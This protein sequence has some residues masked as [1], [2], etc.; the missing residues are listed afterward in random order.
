M[1]SMKPLR[2]R[3]TLW[4]AL[5]LT[6]VVGCRRSDLYTR[7][8]PSAEDPAPNFLVLVVDDWARS[9]LD[10]ARSDGNPWN[11]LINV[12]A[13]ASQ[14]VSWNHFYTQTVCNPT[15]ATM[16]FGVYEG[17]TTGGVCNKPNADTPASD[18]LT[19]ARL[20][21]DDRGYATAAFGKWHIGTN[22]DPAGNWI[23]TPE[24]YGFDHWR[25]W[26]ASNLNGHCSSKS[27]T[28]WHR[29]DDGVASRSTEYHT[30][31]V[32]NAAREWWQATA[33]PKFA[34]VCFQA[35]HA[36]FH[37]PPA[38]LLPSGYPAPTTKHEEYESMLVAL[39]TMV[40]S[41][42]AVVDPD[43]TYVLLLGDNGTPSGAARADQDRSRVKAS[44]FQDGVNVPFIVTGP[45][46]PFGETSSLGHAVDLMATLAELA[47]TEIPT[48]TKTD[49]VSLVPVLRDPTA[50]VRASVICD[51]EDVGST[52]LPV[53]ETAVILE[54][55]SPPGLVKG[56]WLKD[57]IGMIDSQVFYD[58]TVDPLETTPLSQTD[59]L[60]KNTIA[61]LRKI[62]RN[63]V[64]R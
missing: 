31:A 54:S 64:N 10:A 4:V 1:H 3:P 17:D 13:L 57:P 6:S 55:N 56:R 15:R 61:R 51:R 44:A 37:A 53:R 11:D 20:L 19:L 5:L 23:D 50:R 8:A 18:A 46:V 48:G 59:P 21:A 45:D 12:D 40:G 34:Y 9:D 60:Y 14:G 2:R 29:V 32:G 7:S 47:S 42:L 58:L 27:Y 38:W 28:D 41:I 49:S 52:G 30:E 36:P 62:Q 33:G 35:P 24:A 63:Y 16:M 25:A 26:N 43:D 22:P 39:D